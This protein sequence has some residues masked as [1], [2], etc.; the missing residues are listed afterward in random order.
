VVIARSYDD[1]HK[2]SQWL[3]D[4]DLIVADYHLDHQQTGLDALQRMATELDIQAPVL[5]ITA[6]YSNDLKQQIR[7]FGYQLMNKPV[8]PAKLKAVLQHLLS[9]AVEQE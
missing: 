6:N 1:I 5:M 7:A 9:R 8:R 4:L 3:Q 2:Q